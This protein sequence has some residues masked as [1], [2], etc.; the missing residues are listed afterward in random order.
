MT[1]KYEPQSFTLS[2]P[3]QTRSHLTVK[4]LDPSPLLHG[5]KLKSIA[6]NSSS[7]L[8]LWTNEMFYLFLQLSS[9]HKHTDLV[10]KEWLKQYSKDYQNSQNEPKINLLRYVCLNAR[11]L[12]QAE[13][14]VLKMHHPE[15]KICFGKTPAL[16]TPHHLGNYF[17][18]LSVIC[19]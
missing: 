2:M 11:L 14:S 9:S 16:G 5:L 12:K 18:L 1:S 8:T 10:P 7:H 13:K 15:Q 3:P 19:L 17:I 4:G 6:T